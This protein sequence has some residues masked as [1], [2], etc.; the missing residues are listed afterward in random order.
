[1]SSVLTAERPKSCWI[2]VY[3]LLTS[4]VTNRLL[5]GMSSWLWMISRKWPVSRRYE[6]VTLISGVSIFSRCC[7]SGEKIES[8]E[9]TLGRPGGL[10]IEYCILGRC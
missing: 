8:V 6:R 7:V 10:C 4:R 5:G 2:E 1:M 3:K 9:A